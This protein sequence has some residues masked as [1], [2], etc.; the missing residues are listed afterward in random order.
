MEL[1]ESD[2]PV[3]SQLLQKSTRHREALEEEVKEI[4][5][6]TEKIITNALIIGGALA[7]TYYLVRQF[8]KP[9][10]KTKSKIRKP[11]TVVASAPEGEEEEVSEA[12]N[13]LTSVMSQIG[14]TLASQAS[15]FLLTLA[16]EKLNEY[17][18][19]QAAKRK[20]DEHS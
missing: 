16:K 18:E 4:T 15:V 2:D 12:P 1:L 9:A 19:S 7:V 20:A 11:Q 6:R 8:S 10:K 5:G 3:K 13:P 17:L 14:T